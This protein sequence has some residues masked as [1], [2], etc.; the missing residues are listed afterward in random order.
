MQ[1]PKKRGRQTIHIDHWG[2][3]FYPPQKSVKSSLW[4]TSVIGFVEYISSK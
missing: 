1:T 2:A 3:M 4:T